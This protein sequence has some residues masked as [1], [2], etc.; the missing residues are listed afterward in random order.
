MRPATLQAGSR[1]GN[2]RQPWRET[3]VRRHEDGLGDALAEAC[4]TRHVVHL[5]RCSG[6]AC[7]EKRLES[8]RSPRNKP[9]RTTRVQN[10]TMSPSSIGLS[11][12][13]GHAPGRCVRVGGRLARRRCCARRACCR[14]S[15]ARP[16][17]TPLGSV[18]SSTPRRATTSAWTGRASP[19]VRVLRGHR[20]VLQP[21]DG[22]FGDGAMYTSENS[23]CSTCTCPSARRASP[24]R[25]PPRTSRTRSSRSAGPADARR[26]SRAPFSM[27]RNGPRA[28]RAQ[29]VRRAGNERHRAVDV[30][31]GRARLL[32]AHARR[33]RHRVR[34]LRG[35]IRVR[36][37]RRRRRQVE[38]PRRGRGGV[39]RG[40]RQP[41]RLGPNAVHRRRGRHA[42]RRLRQLRHQQVELRQAPAAPERR[43]AASRETPHRLLRRAR[44]RRRGVRGRR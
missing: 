36:R 13:V 1:S 32:L 31:N 19:S 33:G 35:W 5:R 4:I 6:R 20:E 11:T 24:S 21:C 41:H 3:T 2:R 12:L 18:S 27:F 28:L 37:L 15:R 40:D 29:R 30:Q 22:Y 17:R 14:C 39:H 34:R 38:V 26:G 8:F 16:A 9:R 43:V 23:P 10:K 42:A 25:L 44:R 7:G